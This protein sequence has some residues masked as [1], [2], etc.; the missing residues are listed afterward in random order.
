MPLSLAANDPVFIDFAE[1]FAASAVAERDTLKQRV[2]ALEQQIQQLKSDLP[3]N[4]RVIEAK[5]FIGRI[6]ATEM[7]TLASSADP[8]V[9]QILRMLTD[10]TT[11]DW[12]IV[13]DSPEIQGSIPYLISL[14]L[15]TADRVT[16]LLRDCTRDEAYVADG[17]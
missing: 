2:T 5:A 3:Y 6:S 7:L 4:P 16:D 10:W 12:P 14:D 1:Q 15:L 13:L 17:K 11:N 8:Q 9:Q